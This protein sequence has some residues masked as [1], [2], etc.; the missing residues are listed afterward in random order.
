MELYNKSSTLFHN[1]VM[2]CLHN[3]S[4]TTYTDLYHIISYKNCKCEI[5]SEYD[6]CD[7][8]CDDICDDAIIR[9]IIRANIHLNKKSS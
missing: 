8:T 3:D 1:A 7:N 9:A 6:R 4:L 5:C 2:F